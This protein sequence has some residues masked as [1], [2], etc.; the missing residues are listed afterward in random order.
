[1]LNGEAE[2]KMQYAS[3]RH[4]CMGTTAWQGGKRGEYVTA[5]WIWI[6]SREIRQVIQLTFILPGKAEW[7]TKRE[8]TGAEFEASLSCLHFLVIDPGKMMG[9]QSSQTSVGRRDLLSL[10]F[11][12]SF[13]CF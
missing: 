2:A 12:F 3:V 5:T 6:F 11:P 4:A 7:K 8:N 13:S 9:I 10:S 1:M